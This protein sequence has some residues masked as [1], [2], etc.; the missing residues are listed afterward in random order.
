MLKRFFDFC[1]SAVALVLLSP[2]LLFVAIVVRLS[3]PGPAIFAQQRIGRGFKPFFIYKFRSMKEDAPQLGGQ[4]TYGDDPRIT[5]IGRH[6]RKTKIDELPQ[7][8]NVI[9]GDMSFV[10][11][12]PEVNRYVE[13]FRD[14]YAEILRVRPGITDLA[15]LKF[16]DE[17]ALLA[18]SS[19]PEEDYIRSVLPEK[20]R[21]AKKYIEESSFLLDLKIIL[22]TMLSI[23][24]DQAA[25]TAKGLQ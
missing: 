10:G 6:L 16:R 11:P 25:L 20:I 7:L 24:I 4:I 22:K 2:L 17:A 23:L 15:S 12:R 9:R 3:S 5:Q 19:N 18:T 1:V 14:D 21:L 13:M 8:F